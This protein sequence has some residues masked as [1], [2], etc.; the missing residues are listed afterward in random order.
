[1]GRV[2]ALPIVD[3]D[4]PLAVYKPGE[5]PNFEGIAVCQREVLRGLVL[6]SD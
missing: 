2:S 6:G 1:M 4:E 3:V 5:P